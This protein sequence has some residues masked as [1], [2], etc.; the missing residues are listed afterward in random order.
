MKYYVITFLYESRDDCASCGV[1]GVYTLSENATKKLKEISR[2]EIENANV[3]DLSFETSKCNS[4]F[5][6]YD[7]DENWHNTFEIHIVEK[8]EE[9]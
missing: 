3:N 2:E 4:K 7:I 5:E 9:V 8:Q 6:I 1:Y